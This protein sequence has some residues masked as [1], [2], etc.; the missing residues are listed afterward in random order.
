MIDNLELFQAFEDL[1]LD[2]QQMLN[3][4]NVTAE[5]VAMYHEAWWNDDDFYYDQNAYHIC[6][7][8]FLDHP[9]LFGEKP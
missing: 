4:N 7:D 5:H 3:L 9:E 8:V 2:L 6:E 1:A